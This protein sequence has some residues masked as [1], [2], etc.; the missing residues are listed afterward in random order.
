MASAIEFR[1][2]DLR[3][4]VWG[5]RQSKLRPAGRVHR[6]TASPSSPGA[7][8]GRRVGNSVETDS[9]LPTATPAHRPTPKGPRR[10]SRIVQLLSTRHRRAQREASRETSVQVAIV[11]SHVTTSLPKAIA[12]TG[13]LASCAAP[14]VTGEVSTPR[15]YLADADGGIWVAAAEVDNGTLVLAGES[16][17]QATFSWAGD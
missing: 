14:R 15:S 1:R 12:L 16:A 9:G 4:G 13:L 5:L 7:S 10:V 3:L 8:R 17:G 6:F 2:V 11:R